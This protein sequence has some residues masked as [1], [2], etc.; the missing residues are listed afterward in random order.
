MNHTEL[1]AL[2]EELSNCRSYLEFGCGS[3]TKLAVSIK[4]IKKIRL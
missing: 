2:K 1:S 4:S 3:S